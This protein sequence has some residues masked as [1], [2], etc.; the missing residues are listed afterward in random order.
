MYEQRTFKK[1]ELKSWTKE[2]QI[3]V[4][5]IQELNVNW[6]KIKGKYAIDE[7][8]K[9]EDGSNFKL[10]FAYRKNENRLLYQRGGLYVHSSGSI[11]FSSLQHG[12]DPT[13][14]G[15]WTWTI[16]QGFQCFIA[17]I[18]SLV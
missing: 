10:S 14:F 13:L 11:Q 2:H 6:L 12:E 1:D 5:Y 7:R 18:I 4:T 9:T 16:F 17:R 8:F 15:R 3:I